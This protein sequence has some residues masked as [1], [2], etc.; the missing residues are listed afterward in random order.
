MSK[1]KF[2]EVVLLSVSGD[3]IVSTL[4][5][6]RATVN[7]FNSFLRDSGFACIDGI[8]YVH[9]QRTLLAS[10]AS[11]SVHGGEWY[12]IIDLAER[13]HRFMK[14]DA[15]T[16]I[17]RSSEVLS[18]SNGTLYI[19]M[20][21]G[22]SFWDSIW[23]VAVHL[24]Q[25]ARPNVIWLNEV[26]DYDVKRRM[27]Y[28]F[29][30]SSAPYK[31]DG[32]GLVNGYYKRD[33]EESD[34]LWIRIKAGKVR[35]LDSLPIDFLTPAFDNDDPEIHAFCYSE[36]QA[37]VL[38]DTTGLRLCTYL[39]VT[40]TLIVECSHAHGGSVYLWRC[41]NGIRYCEHCNTWF[42]VDEYEEHLRSKAQ[43]EF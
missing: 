15:L 1:R 24:Q 3:V 12:V 6:S 22:T 42:F 25:G 30:E 33:P 34:S 16:I 26:S 4:L 21:L 29:N 19:P 40:R 37:F 5:S 23:C 36:G 31:L 28:A 7:D 8:V 17:E 39:Q 10:D 35:R 38:Q 18:V 20:F 43:R 9:G 13:G 27:Y 41:D 14:A 2:I 11:A 32:G